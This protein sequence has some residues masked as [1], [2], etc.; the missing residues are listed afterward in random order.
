V[1]TLALSVQ[2]ACAS[3][4]LSWKAWREHVEPEV[5][6]VRLGRSKRVSVRELERFLD[7]HGEQLIAHQ[8]NGGLPR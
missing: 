3:L 7:E 1:P 4:G 6:V 5:R 2:E 8:L